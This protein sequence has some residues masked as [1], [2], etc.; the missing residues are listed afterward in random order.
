MPI[1]AKQSAFWFQRTFEGPVGL[2]PFRCLFQEKRLVDEGV[3]KSKKNL[4]SRGGWALFRHSLFYIHCLPIFAAHDD[5][6]SIF[7]PSG[8]DD[9]HGQGEGNQ[10]K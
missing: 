5:L 6:I 10:K 7:F 1:V 8:Y 9:A 2:S 3:E 4:S